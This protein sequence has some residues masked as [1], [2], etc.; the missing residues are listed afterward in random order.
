MTGVTSTHGD[1]QRDALMLFMRAFK[2]DNRYLPSIAEMA[3]DL[4]MQR[5]AVV[6]HLEKLRE[7]G[8]VDYVDGKMSRSLRLRR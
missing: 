1:K 2:H 8:R 6:W 4:N 5:T 7:E 3:S